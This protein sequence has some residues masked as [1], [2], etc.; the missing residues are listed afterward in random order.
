MCFYLQTKINRDREGKEGEKGPPSSGPIL[1]LYL[2]SF[3]YLLGSVMYSGGTNVTIP[4]RKVPISILIILS[5]IAK[6]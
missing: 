6:F 3:C 5:E 2:F 1:G 4:L